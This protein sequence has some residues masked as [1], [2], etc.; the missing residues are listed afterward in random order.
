M[1][2][3]VPFELLTAI[4]YGYLGSSLPWST[5]A[6]V[7]EALHFGVVVVA[8]LALAVGA[9]RRA[10]WVP[11][12]AVVLTAWVGIPTLAMVAGAVHIMRGLVSPALPLAF[13][14][15]VCAAVC[16][17]TALIIALRHLEVRSAAV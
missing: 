16:Q 6:S 1:R 5:A 12:A 2:S 8:C 3:L 17:L 13:G 10:G 14:L 11:K 15:T 7:I 4:I 9:W